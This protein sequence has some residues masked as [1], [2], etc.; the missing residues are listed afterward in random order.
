VDPTELL[1]EALNPLLQTLGRG[2]FVTYAPDL[3]SAVRAIAFGR[4]LQTS[5]VVLPKKR[6]S[7]DTIDTHI[8]FDPRTFL[9]KLHKMYG[10]DISVSCSL[11]DVRGRYVIIREDEMGTGTTAIATAD[12]LR[13]AGAKGVYL[14]ATHAVCTS[15]WNA[16]LKIDSENPPFD[17]VWLGNTRPRGEE[18]GEREST[19]GGIDHV[20]LAPVFARGMIAAIQKVVKKHR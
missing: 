11:T 7:G 1:A 3:G 9:Q 14:I 6:L 13:D 20:D 19:G 2:N 17:G 10:I 5:V 4:V 16:K 12:K 15:G 18:G 8:T